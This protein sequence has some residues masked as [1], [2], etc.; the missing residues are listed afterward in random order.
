[1]E[2]VSEIDN[3][4]GTNILIPKLTENEAT[5]ELNTFKMMA[6]GIL[7][8]EIPKPNAPLSSLSVIPREIQVRMLHQKKKQM[9]SIRQVLMGQRKKSMTK[10]IVHKERDQPSKYSQ[11]ICKITTI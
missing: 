4:K 5:P 9:R 2:K 1:M 10:A 7:H 11:S 3:G 8:C 6:R